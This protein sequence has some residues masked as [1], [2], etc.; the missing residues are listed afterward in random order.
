MT[1]YLA[2]RIQLTYVLLGTPESLPGQPRPLRILPKEV[3]P[4]SNRHMPLHVH[5]VNSCTQSKLEGG[6]QQL[7]S[8]DD[9]ATKWLKTLKCTRQQQ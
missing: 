7:H 5:I 6:L 1:H 3:G 4:C 9:V 8:A 2:T